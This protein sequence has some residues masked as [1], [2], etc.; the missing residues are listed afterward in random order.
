MRGTIVRDGD[1]SEE[2]AVYE[3]AEDLVT[4]RDLIER[5]YARAGEHLRSIFT[6]ERRIPAEDLVALLPG[7]RCGR[8]PSAS[9]R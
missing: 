6:P 2:G 5:S 4:L 7:C 8:R 9:A 3:T 1:A